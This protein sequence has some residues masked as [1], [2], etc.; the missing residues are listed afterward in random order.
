M[1]DVLE[2][3]GDLR[4]GELYTY[5]RDSW[6]QGI[7][8]TFHINFRVMTINCYSLDSLEVLGAERGKAL[9]WHCA[10]CY[11]PVILDIH[12]GGPSQ[13]GQTGCLTVPD[14]E[15]DQERLYDRNLYT[16]PRLWE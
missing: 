6:D 1:Y 16:L 15:Q 9:W 14:L 13:Q 11:Q 12:S 4:F 3:V 5:R 7:K 8:F 2:G 10:L